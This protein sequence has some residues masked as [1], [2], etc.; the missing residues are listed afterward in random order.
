MNMRNIPLIEVEVTMVDLELLL[1]MMQD[2]KYPIYVL[3]QDNGIVFDYS[4]SSEDDDS[5]FSSH[6]ST[7]QYKQ[8]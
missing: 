6:F 4:S 8:Y 7:R 1:T 2:L 5:S 3:L